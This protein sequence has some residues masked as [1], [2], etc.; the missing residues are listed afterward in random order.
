[1]KLAAY[2][3]NRPSDMDKS[4]LTMIPDAPRIPHPVIPTNY[5]WNLLEENRSSNTHSNV[6]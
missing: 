5:D 6:I 1:M 4:L 2:Y 3:K